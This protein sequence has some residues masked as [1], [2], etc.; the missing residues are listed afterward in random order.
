MDDATLEKNVLAKHPEYSDLPKSQTPGASQITGISQDPANKLFSLPWFKRQ[1][2]SAVDSLTQDLPAIG[3]TLGA[4]AG[5][6]GGPIGSIGGSGMGAMAGT[7]GKQLVRRWMG[8]GDAPATSGQAANEITGQ[9]L[10]NAVLQAGG[11]GTSSVLKKAAP[12]MAE[13]ALNVTE[14]MRG[15]GRTIGQAALDETSGVSPATIKTQAGARLGELTSQME[16]AVH[17]ATSSGAT[18][19]TLPAHQALN[20]AIDSMP[21]NAH[22]LRAK[23]MDLG[24]LLDLRPQGSIGPVPTTY[25][26]DELLEIKRGIGKEIQSWPPEW[27]KMSDVKNVQSKLYGALDGELDRLVSGNASANQKIS[28][29]IPVKQ[30]AARLSDAASTTQRI[31]HR[32]TAHTGALAGSGIGGYLGYREG[33]PKGAA[34][35]AAAGLALPELLASPTAQMTGARLTQAAGE[36]GVPA[37]LPFLRVLASKNPGKNADDEKKQ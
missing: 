24:G 35:G 14:R 10:T 7:A 17:Q 4:F 3:G 22:S 18:G 31:A 36:S 16:D 33:G 25:S 15:R 30:Q 5:S 6:E 1:G 28:S 29:L 8:F 32:V 12:K 9:G 19:S 34:I 21:R 23:I 37:S 26:P 13:S 2:I 20:D 27:Q 11:E